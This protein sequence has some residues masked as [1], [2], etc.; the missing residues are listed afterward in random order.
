MLDFQGSYFWRQLATYVV[1]AAFVGV[2]LLVPVLTPVAVYLAPIGMA[3]LGVAGTKFM[4]PSPPPL[5]Q[6]NERKITPPT[7]Q[8][9][10]T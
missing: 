10:G 3:M 4:K 8:G 2:P 9:P 7:G 6:Q 1:G 5:L